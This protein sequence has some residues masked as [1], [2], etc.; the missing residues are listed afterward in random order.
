MDSSHLT[1]I[2]SLFQ[3]L[4][5]LLNL[6]EMADKLASHGLTDFVGYQALY[7]GDPKYNIR[8][9]DCHSEQGIQAK[10]Q[11]IKALKKALKIKEVSM[12]IH[13]LTYIVSEDLPECVEKIRR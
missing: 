10:D 9:E 6:G 13:L 4:L 5:H 7:F 11:L 8:R 2:N 12:Y 3:E 1:P